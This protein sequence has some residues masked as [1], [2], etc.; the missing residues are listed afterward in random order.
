MR[1]MP[2]TQHLRTLASRTITVMVLGTKD[3]KYFVL[4][5]SKRD[6]RELQVGDINLRAQSTLLKCGLG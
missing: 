1:E 4:G 3:L 5:P 6:Q 2:S